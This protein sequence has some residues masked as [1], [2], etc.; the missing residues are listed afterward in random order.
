MTKI[1]GDRHI[2]FCMGI[3][4]HGKSYLT[5]KVIIPL[6]RQPVIILDPMDEYQGRV[7]NGADE[8]RAAVKENDYEIPTGKPNVIKVGRG[9]RRDAEKMFAWINFVEVPVSLVVEECDR[10]CG[11]NYIDPNFEDLL[12]VGGHFDVTLI[13]L[14]RRFAKVHKDIEG[15]ADFHITFRQKY[16]GDLKRLDNYQQDTELIREMDR[17][18]FICFGDIREP[19]KAAGFK[20]NK[21]LTVN[22]NKIKEVVL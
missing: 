3:Q 7:F 2:I 6:L 4:R 11:A 8:F 1:E 5:K 10:W 13:C 16:V 19:F 9:R 22:G 21:L 15:L 12:N 18:E 14:A 20:E 17:R